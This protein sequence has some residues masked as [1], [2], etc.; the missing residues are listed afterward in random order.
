MSNMQIIKPTIRSYVVKA[1]VS[2]EFRAPKSGH[3]GMVVVNEEGVRLL[4]WCSARAGFF[5]SRD[6]IAA[7]TDVLIKAIEA[8]EEAAAL[9]PVAA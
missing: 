9:E 7:P 2:A 6:D 1:S 4:S 5:P 3:K 8:Y